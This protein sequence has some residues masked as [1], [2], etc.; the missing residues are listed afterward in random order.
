M[1]FEIADPIPFKTDEAYYILRDE[2]SALVP[3]ME[4]TES[5]KVIKREQIEGEVRLT[6]HW[7]A[8]MNKIPSAIRSFVKP[9]MLSWHD[10]VIWTDQDKTGRWELEALG[11]DKLFS[12]KGETSVIEVGDETQLKIV[13]EFEIYPE[14]V[15][16]I[17]KFLA[18]KIGGQ[19]EKLIGEILSS[20]M[21]QMAQSMSRY[22]ASK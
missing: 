11:S 18:K 10:H 5:I 19:V 12:C 1:K 20:N 13:L 22:A 15:P 14:K 9:E 21:R 8:S 3:F 6:N 17:P 4:D 2:M 16:G 7:Q